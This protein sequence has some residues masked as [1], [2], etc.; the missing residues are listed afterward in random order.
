[1]YAHNSVTLSANGHSTC[2]VTMSI[3]MMTHDAHKTPIRNSFFGTI[4]NINTHIIITAAVI[5][6]FILCCSKRVSQKMITGLLCSD[7]CLLAWHHFFENNTLPSTFYFLITQHAKNKKDE[8]FETKSPFS[9][10]YK[11]DL[12]RNHTLY[13]HFFRKREKIACE[14]TNGKI[15]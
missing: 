5:T 2:D 12:W 9:W 1:M 3:C 14:S 7:L 4:I 10:A 8:L 13:I 15:T 11:L 6:R